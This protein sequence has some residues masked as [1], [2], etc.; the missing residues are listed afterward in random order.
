MLR[1][2]FLIC[3]MLV[4]Q[5]NAPARAQGNKAAVRVEIVATA[6]EYVPRS[7]T[8]SH[9][10][11]AYTNCFGTTSYFGEF[12]SYGDRGSF[13]GTADTNTRC[14]TTFSPPTESTLTTYRRVNYTIARGDQAL[15][16]LSC[17]QTW[18][19]TAGE[20]VRLGIIAVV[21]PTEDA[22]LEAMSRL[23]GHKTGHSRRPAQLPVARNAASAIQ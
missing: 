16:L 20:R 3:A 21:H 2:T 15:Y 18:K 13:S 6:S 17:T 7:M 12:E 1:R 19:P 22:V 10:G 14:A 5:W 4:F 11:H 8:V 9:P 23:G